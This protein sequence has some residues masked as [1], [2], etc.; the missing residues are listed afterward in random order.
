[1]RELDNQIETLR[2]KIVIYTFI[3]NNTFF[4]EQLEVRKRK[5]LMVARLETPM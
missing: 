5:F 1:M 2:N 4:R 3:V